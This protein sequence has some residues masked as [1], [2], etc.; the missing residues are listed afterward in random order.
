[1]RW[2]RSIPTHA[3]GKSLG[4]I[5]DRAAMPNRGYA[6]SESILVLLPRFAGCSVWDEKTAATFFV[7]TPNAKKTG[8]V[9]TKR[10]KGLRVRLLHM[11]ELGLGRVKT[12]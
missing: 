10:K 8:V 6:R 11:S 4:R 5:D 1:L 3:H 7:N 12:R 2:T 9:Q